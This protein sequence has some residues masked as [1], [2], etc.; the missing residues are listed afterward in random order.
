MEI[1][2]EE[3]V[4]EPEII[5]PE[6]NEVSID[7]QKNENNR[8]PCP[9]CNSDF[10]KKSSVKIHIE[11]VHHK[12]KSFFCDICGQEF[13]HSNSVKK[14][15]LRSCKGVK[16]EQHGDKWTIQV[17]QTSVREGK[18][19]CEICHKSFISEDGLSNH[20]T[21]S[22]NTE[23]NFQCPHCEKSFKVRQSYYRH[24]HKHEEKFSFQC[25]QCNR[26]YPDSSSLDSHVTM[27]HEKE[28]NFF[29]E[30]CGAAFTRLHS[31][32]MHIKNAHPNA[33]VEVKRKN[34]ESG[35]FNCKHCAETFDQENE[36][37]RHEH[38][39]HMKFACSLCPARY[40]SQEALQQ[41]FTFLHE[42]QGF[43]CKIC[44]VAF[45]SPREVLEHLISFHGHKILEKYVDKKNLSECKFVDMGSNTNNSTS[46]SEQIANRI[47]PGLTPGGQF[48]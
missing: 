31:A 24:L 5:M 26:K 12:K 1:K 9:M 27:V 22:H 16:F 14:H 46:L 11:R 48:Y 47:D 21:S 15:K 4:L 34:N 32:K 28:R 33:E 42:E 37:I 18:F 3:I 30:M 35:K 2:M 39:E 38:F 43:E 7:V 23:K 19:L 17:K 13:S 44:L 36:M 20:L 25:E 8:W 6:Y 29:C 45:T 40:L 10:T 41:H